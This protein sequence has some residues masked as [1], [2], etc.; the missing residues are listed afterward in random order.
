MP[1]LLKEQNCLSIEKILFTTSFSAPAE[2]ALPY[3]AMFARHYGSQVYVDPA[4]PTPLP[5]LSGR[6]LPV[7]CDCSRNEANQ[8]MEIFLRTAPLR[9][10]RL[11]RI[12]RK[13]PHELVVA[14]MVKTLKI[15]LVVA[16][17]HGRS[18]FKKLLLGS[19]AEDIPCSVPCSALIVGPNVTPSDVVRGGSFE[20]LCA[21]DSSGSSHALKYAADLAFDYGARLSVLHVQAYGRL[22]VYYRQQSLTTVGAEL[23]RLIVSFCKTPEIPELIVRFGSVA[24]NVLELAHELKATLI[25]MGV[26]HPAI[27]QIAEH[28]PLSFAQE[29]VWRARCPVILVPP[30]SPHR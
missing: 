7:E 13:G 3:A 26:Q 22:P 8:A 29:V 20:I 4:I 21:I 24:D 27:A 25:V 6:G 12:L 1:A 30:A 23:K 14:D 10:L 2:N 16:A 11:K 15:D 17:T 19:V 18:G 28:L 9:G 5:A